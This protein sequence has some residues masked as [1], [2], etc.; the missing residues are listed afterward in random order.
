M[1]SVI[2]GAPGAAVMNEIDKESRKLVQSDGEDGRATG[3]WFLST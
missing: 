3:L 2:S 1:N